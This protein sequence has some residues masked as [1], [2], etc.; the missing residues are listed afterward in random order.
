MPRPQRDPM[1]VGRIIGDVLDPF[2]KSIEIRIAYTSRNLT[3]GCELKPSA[4]VDHPRVE[5]GG[6]DMR[7]FYTLVMVDPDAPSP[8]DPSLREYLHWLVTDIPGTTGATYGMK[9][10][11]N[12][13]KSLHP[14]YFA[15][16]IF[17]KENEISLFCLGLQCIMKHNLLS[18][19]TF[20]SYHSF[21]FFLLPFSKQIFWILGIELVH[22]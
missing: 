13:K 9:T 16:F 1:V 3:S 5:I 22:D 12:E 10:K 19:C 15:A 4:V 20:F 2:K 6:D 14:N 11:L 17:D 7:T 21:H 18:N 8:S